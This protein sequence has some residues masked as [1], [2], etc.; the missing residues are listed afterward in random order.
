MKEIFL[1]IKN[2]RGSTKVNVMKNINFYI[3]C[4]LNTFENFS[5]LELLTKAFS[6]ENFFPGFDIN[7]YILLFKS[8]SKLI[9]RK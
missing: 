6:E 2:P 5:I 8:Y 4:F 7:I 1:S 3:S 9:T